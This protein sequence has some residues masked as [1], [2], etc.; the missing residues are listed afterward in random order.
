MCLVACTLLPGSCLQLSCSADSPAESDTPRSQPHALQPHRSPRQPAPHSLQGLLHF[1]CHRSPPLFPVLGPASSPSPRSV[2]GHLSH[3][4]LSL[5]CGRGIII[6]ANT[7]RLLF[8]G[9]GCDILRS[10]PPCAWVS[11]PGYPT[12]HLVKSRGLPKVTQP[13]PR[14]L[15]ARADAVPEDADPGSGLYK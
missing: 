14:T 2:P 8:A 11:V 13:T 15:K 12:L 4:D 6:R 10:P 9:L 3:S 1:R 7:E 5:K